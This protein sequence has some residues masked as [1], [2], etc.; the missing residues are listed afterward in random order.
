L[1]KSSKSQ[2]KFLEH[3]IESV[4]NIFDDFQKLVHFKKEAW[5]EKDIN[6]L[7]DDMV[8]NHLSEEHYM[9]KEK[10]PIIS[11]KGH[12]YFPDD[13]QS[14]FKKRF[15]KLKT[16]D[17][18][19][20]M[21]NLKSSLKPEPFVRSS[22]GS[23]M[24]APISSLIRNHI[25]EDKLKIVNQ[26]DIFINTEGIEESKLKTEN[27]LSTVYSDKSQTE[28][29][30][31][32]PKQTEDSGNRYESVVNKTHKTVGKAKFGSTFITEQPRLPALPHI[33]HLSGQSGVESL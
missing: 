33:S 3:K 2:K 5:Y 18:E 17:R 14:R 23:V 6:E 32:S 15:K 29:E 13:Q 16:M 27:I 25:T 28:K 20:S 8:I 31:S 1:Q 26:R 24:H 7:Y 10:K 11:L 21:P 12:D 9:P 4:N 30:K 19:T 22:R